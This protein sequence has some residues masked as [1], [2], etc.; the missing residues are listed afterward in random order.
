MDPFRLQTG[1]RLLSE[2]D[3]LFPLR[4]PDFMIKWRNALMLF[5]LVLFII[6][7]PYG[8]LVG[9]TDEGVTDLWVVRHDRGRPAEMVLAQT[10]Q[11]LTG[12]KKPKLWLETGGMSAVILEQ[13]RAE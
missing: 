12:R 4:R 5:M 3:R 1:L 8:P 13:L 6:G 11:G 2:F 10:L 9:H 7:K